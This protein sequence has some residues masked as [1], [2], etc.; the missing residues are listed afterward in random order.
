MKTQD[1]FQDEGSVAHY[2]PMVGQSKRAEEQKLPVA[3]G[4]ND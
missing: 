2:L 3:R 1:L 4:D